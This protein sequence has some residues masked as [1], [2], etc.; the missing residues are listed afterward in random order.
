MTQQQRKD[1]MNDATAR[2]MRQY[3]NTQQQLAFAEGFVQCAF[4]IDMKMMSVID[5]RER[6]PLPGERVLAI[7]TDYRTDDDFDCEAQMLRY[8]KELF[9][10]LGVRHWVPFTLNIVEPNKTEKQ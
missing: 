5:I 1:L 10:K 9:D 3:D 4:D 6:E 2:A 7:K 8:D